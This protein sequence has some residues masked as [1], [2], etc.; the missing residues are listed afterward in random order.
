MLRPARVA[1][2]LALGA[3]ACGR[4]PAPLPVDP[5][6]S[7]AAHR[8]GDRFVVDRLQD[9]GSGVLAPPGRFHGD[10]PPSFVLR[11][12]EQTRAG[13]WVIGRSRVLARAAD[14]TRAPRSGEVLSDWNEGAIRLTLFAR[15]GT[16]LR[17]D[18]FLR[19]DGRA[20]AH[21]AAPRPGY[22]AAYR[23]A[24]RDAKGAAVGWMRV[25]TANRLYDGVLPA[26]V[27]DALA[28]AATVALDGEVTWLADH[29]GTG[30]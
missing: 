4:P 11:V 3:S 17:T 20:L 29:G 30:E 16:V 13:V 21:D 14:S 23:A 27:D 28:A 24:L 5:G 22:G 26:E 8:D 25:Q 7:F 2:V 6:V 12:D 9:G 1:L 15:D 19:A 18:T 10:S